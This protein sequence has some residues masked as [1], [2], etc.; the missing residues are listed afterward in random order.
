MLVSSAVPGDGKTT[1]TVNF[2][3]T[4][5]IA[6]NRVLLIDADLRRGNIHNYFGL[7]REP[8]L[9]EALDGTQT[10]REVVC[11]TEIPTL[12][13]ITSGKLP[14]HP[15][16]LL[17]SPTMH[18]AMDEARIDYDYIVVDCPPLT[19]ID[20]AFSLI[21]LMN[22]LLFVVRS[23]QT[24]MRFAKTALA[25][26]RQ[27][28]ASILGIVLNGITADNPYYY[29]NYYYHAYYN[30]SSRDAQAEASER[31]ASDRETGAKP[32]AVPQG[33]GRR[34]ADK[35]ISGEAMAIAGQRPSLR[36]IEKEAATKAELFKARRA[37]RKIEPGSSAD[38][39]PL[40]APSPGE[41]P[42]PSGAGLSP[43]DSTAPQTQEAPADLR[44]GT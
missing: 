33:K 30:K 9:T 31:E 1:F 8:G 18:R 37:A 7:L 23:G 39:S 11:E 41:Q 36:Q 27:R 32:E 20:D 21:G 40:S 3:A 24:S 34:L 4:L 43:A 38:T 44:N 2:A 26:V 28:G 14:A 13:V 12:Q 5:A 25:A 29:Y 17:V 22:G 15:G 6:G 10:W 19:A 16:E 35:S 42:G